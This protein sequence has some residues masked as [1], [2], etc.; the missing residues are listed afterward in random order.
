LTRGENV[1]KLTGLGGG[2]KMPSMSCFLALRKGELDFS[3]PPFHCQEKSAKG[4]YFFYLRALPR[5][6]PGTSGLDPATCCSVGGKA[7]TNNQ[8]IQKISEKSKK[9]VDNLKIKCRFYLQK[10]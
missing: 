3:S 2:P 8:K 10:P 9:T 4:R 5:T 6:P 7:A 1:F